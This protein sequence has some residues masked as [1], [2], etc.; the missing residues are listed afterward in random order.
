MAT[1]DGYS[2]YPLGLTAADATA[3]IRRAYNLNTEFL[4]YVRYKESDV[5]PIVSTVKQGDIWYNT[6]TKSIYRAYIEGT[7]LLW[8][9]V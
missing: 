1:N 9:E 3:A 5:A 7:T 2:P 6:T 4:G 8:L